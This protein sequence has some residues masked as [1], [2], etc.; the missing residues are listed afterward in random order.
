ME[1][2]DRV[3]RGMAFRLIA[4]GMKR[5]VKSLTKTGA[6]FVKKTAGAVGALRKEARIGPVVHEQVL[7]ALARMK[8]KNAELGPALERAHA[9]AIIPSIGKASA[10]LG[11]AYGLG[12]VFEGKNKKMI[13]YAAL[14]Q[15]TIGLQLGGETF[16]EIVVF[17]DAASLK[18]FKAGK[19]AFA[20]NAAVALPKASAVASRGF[21]DGTRI[22]VSSEGGLQLGVAIGGQRF[23]YR[24]AAFGRLRWLAKKPRRSS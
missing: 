16:H 19:T 21:G 11:G 2:A 10:V 6:G 12:E 15:L 20:A 18:R 13:G 4:G 9:F 24:P 3:M 1:G 22:F 5:P 14:V 23:V 8:E 17:P 7:A